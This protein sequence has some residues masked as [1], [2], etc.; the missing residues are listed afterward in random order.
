MIYFISIGIRTFQS[1][2]ELLLNAVW[3]DRHNTKRE[4][5]THRTIQTLENKKKNFTVE[6]KKN[7]FQL[8]IHY[9]CTGE[10]SIF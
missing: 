3:I 2:G 10:C 6:R 7:A 1:D 4:K 5:Q 9:D 8:T